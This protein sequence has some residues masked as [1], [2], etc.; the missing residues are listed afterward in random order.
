M[1]NSDDALRA[2]IAKGE[3]INAPGDYR[4]ARL[5]I[6]VPEEVRAALVSEAHI[7]M[8]TSP[9]HRP[10]GALREAISVWQRTGKFPQSE[11]VREERESRK[12]RGVR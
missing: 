8:N 12:R 3:D 10:S 11:W 4:R 7:I 5:L 2:I 6:E 9:G 1:S